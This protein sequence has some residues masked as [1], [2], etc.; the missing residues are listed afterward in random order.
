MKGAVIE[1]FLCCLNSNYFRHAS[2]ISRCRWK[3]A[4]RSTITG[5]NDEWM[6]KQHWRDKKQRDCCEH[7]SDL[8]VRKRTFF[9]LL[10]V[11]HFSGCRDH[12]VSSLSSLLCVLSHR[13]ALSFCQL[14]IGN[15]AV[16]VFGF[17]FC[18]AQIYEYIMFH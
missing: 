9:L 8:F 6:K 4:C 12:R 11:Y 7:F 14:F 10:L 15:C 16:C 17:S 13:R 1:Q 18:F 5:E 3:V 2:E